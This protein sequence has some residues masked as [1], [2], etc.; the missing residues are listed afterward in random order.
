MRV[1]VFGRIIKG[2]RNIIQLKN[3]VTFYHFFLFLQNNNP[4]RQRALSPNLIIAKKFGVNCRLY[5]IYTRE[6]AIHNEI[7][8]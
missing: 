1:Y 7:K 3:S 4:K 5:L 8:K 6:Q 2:R